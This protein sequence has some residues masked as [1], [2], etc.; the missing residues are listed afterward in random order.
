MAVSYNLSFL[1]HVG[2][3]SITC[4]CQMAN[5][6]RAGGLVLGRRCRLMFSLAG[7]SPR[8]P[9]TYV[10]ATSKC[11]VCR[12]A[13]QGGKS[14]WGRYSLESRRGGGEGFIVLGRDL[15]ETQSISYR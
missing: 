4:I 1:L 8:F 11:R 9:G 7:G 6:D 2:L 14:G 5:I 10:V 13:L 3:L 15:T 12:G